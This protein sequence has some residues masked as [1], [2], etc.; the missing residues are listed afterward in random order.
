MKELINTEKAPKAIGPYSQGNKAGDFIFI[1][2]QLPI[3]PANGE[4]NKGCIK[5]QTKLVIENIKAIL[6]A[7]GCTLDAA[8]MVQVFMTD[9]SKFQEMNEMYS[10]YFGTSI[11]SRVA[12]GVS[13][14]PKGADIEMTLVAYKG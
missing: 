14:L 6:E 4:I 1:S 12:V 11:P 9:L 13:Q 3:N 5:E 2:G 10:E 8:V 7:A